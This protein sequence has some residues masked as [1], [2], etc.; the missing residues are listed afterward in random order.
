[1][2]ISAV[3][4]VSRAPCVVGD[5]AAARYVMEKAT[6]ELGRWSKEGFESKYENEVIIRL[7]HFVKLLIWEI[8]Q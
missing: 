8:Q 4:S 5:L 1:M 3:T 6:L 2:R 7:L